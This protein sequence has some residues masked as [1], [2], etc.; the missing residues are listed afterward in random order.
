MLPHCPV[1]L[2]PFILLFVIAESVMMIVGLVSFCTGF[3]LL[4]DWSENNFV[5]QQHHQDYHLHAVLC[6]HQ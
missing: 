2:S 5:Q 4:I 3:D 6:P 1:L